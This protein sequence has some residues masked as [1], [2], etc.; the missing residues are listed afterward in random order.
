MARKDLAQAK[1][2]KKDEFYTKLDDIAKELKTIVLISKIRLYSAT[3]MI[4]TKVISSSTLPS[5]STH[6]G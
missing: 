5:I 2:A 6:W 4:H 1:D 3:V